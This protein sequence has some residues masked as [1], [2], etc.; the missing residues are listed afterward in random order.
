MARIGETRMKWSIVILLVV[1]VIAATAAAVLVA[2]LRTDNLRQVAQIGLPQ[3]ADVT[4]VVARK[5]LPAM[6]TIDAQSIG[7]QMV[8][9]DKV[10]PHALTST[11]EAVGKV[12]ALPLVEGQALS[13]DALAPEGTGSQLAAQLPKGMR[14]M[15]VTVSD[16]GG[17]HGILYPGCAVDVLVAIKRTT[18]DEA[19]QTISTILLENVPV[20]AVDQQTVVTPRNDKKQNAEVESAMTSRPRDLKVTLR[21]DLQQAKALQLGQDVGTLT[22][23]LRN[24]QDKEKNRDVGPVSLRVLAGGVEN[25][26][27]PGLAVVPATL[28]PVARIPANTEPTATAP[29]VSPQYEQ[30][31]T[32]IMHGDSVETRTFPMPVTHEPRN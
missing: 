19:P 12:L 27:E 8:A 28:V 32:V 31:Q 21:V 17:L 26:W 6:T 18:A 9:A 5:A 23:A 30:W 2:A 16:A 14:A 25:K 10:P 20:L 11:L 3:P 29:A 13:S 22:L 15:A 24:P 4:V 7:I 1:G